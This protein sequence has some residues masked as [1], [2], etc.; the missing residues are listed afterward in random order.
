MTV[1]FHSCPTVSPNVGLRSIKL[2]NRIFD[3]FMSK[4]SYQ[5]MVTVDRRTSYSTDE[6][7]D[8]IK[9]LNLKMEKNSFDGSNPI[10]VFCLLLR[11]VDEAD[12][13]KL[14]EAQAFVAPLT[15]LSDPVEMQF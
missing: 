8:L 12:M 15:F 9:K 5:L 7:G 13:I 11:F 6:V 3:K 1:L 10:T 4:L 14:S 2:A